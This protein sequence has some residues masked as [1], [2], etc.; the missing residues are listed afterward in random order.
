MEKVCSSSISGLRN[1]VAWLNCSLDLHCR[2]VG[3]C[4]GRLGLRRLADKGLAFFRQRPVSEANRPESEK[5][6]KKALPMTGG[7]GDSWTRTNDP[8]D[9]NDVLYRLSHATM[10]FSIAVIRSFS[11]TC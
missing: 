7:S 4:E 3:P 2:T 9:V 6:R 8:I 11:R 10:D 5:G 1:P